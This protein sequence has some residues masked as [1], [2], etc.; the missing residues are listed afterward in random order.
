M[1]PEEEILVRLIGDGVG[2]NLMT[3]MVNELDSEPLVGRLRQFRACERGIAVRCDVMQA[4]RVECARWI[5]RT[6]W[7]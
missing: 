2:R 6:G 5:T 3:V 4:T 7:C 1:K